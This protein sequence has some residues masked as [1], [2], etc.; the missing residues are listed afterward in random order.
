MS[1]WVEVFPE[2]SFQLH[3]TDS[4]STIKAALRWSIAVQNIRIDTESLAI[5]AFYSLVW[6]TRQNVCAAWW[7]ARLEL[8]RRNL[9]LMRPSGRE[10]RSLYA[11]VFCAVT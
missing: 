8:R 1:V 5:C 10:R 11:F 6:P 2:Q 3:R 9:N 7:D 4:A